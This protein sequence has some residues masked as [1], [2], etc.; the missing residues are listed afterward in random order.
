MR[1]LGVAAGVVALAIAALLAY[2]A[3]RPDDFRV[4]RSATIQAPPE[5]IYANLA[6][7]QR[8]PAWSP[9][10]KR[11]PQMKRTMSTPSSGKGATY[12]WQGNKEVGSGRMRIVDAQEAKRLGIKIDFLEPFEAH[13][14][15]EFTLRPKD[16]GTEV[17]WAMHGPATLITKLMG[18]FFS[19]DAMIGRDFEAGLASLKA[20]AEK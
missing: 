13:N 19:M 7:F 10:E 11:D 16:G 9:W 3:T 12:A 4:Q 20:V 1:V 17:T 8:W 14:D 15:V 18:L 5:R 6:D 2:A